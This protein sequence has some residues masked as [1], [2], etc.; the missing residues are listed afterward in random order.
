MQDLA[1]AI[2]NQ[3]AVESVRISIVLKKPKSDKA[4][5]DKS[6]S[7]GRAGRSNRPLVSPSI[8]ETKGLVNPY[9]E[10]FGGIVMTVTKQG[11][12][13]TMRE[14]KASWMVERSV[15]RV[16]MSFNVPK[17]SCPTID[18]LKAYIAESDLF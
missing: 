10:S 6:S 16:T 4:D 1:E 3:K 15:E 17:A 8:T 7:I 18:D 2:E 14:N 13:Y 12:I 5:D 9:K 11:K